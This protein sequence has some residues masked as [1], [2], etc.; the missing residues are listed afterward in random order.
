MSI[1]CWASQ[2]ERILAMPVPCQSHSAR[3][4]IVIALTLQI[5]FSG[6]SWNGSTVAAASSVA[7]VSSPTAPTIQPAL[8]A[9]KPHTGPG[10]SNYPNWRNYTN[11]SDVFAIATNPASNNVWLG[12]TGGVVKLDQ[13]TGNQLAAYTHAD[14]LAT[15]WTTALALD[16]AGKI[17]AGSLG[18]GV[19]RFD[20][21][22]WQVYNTSNSG[23]LANAI[24]TI[25]TDGQGNVWF[26]TG[27]P[28]YSN[29]GTGV[30]KFDGSSW[31]TFSTA[32]S[33]L[34][35]N[36]VKGIAFDSSVNPNVWF[37]TNNGI[38]K[39]SGVNNWQTYNA[40]NLGLASNNTKAV[41]VDGANNI[42]IA[43]DAGVSRFNPGGNSWQNF[44]TSNSALASNN[45][46]SIGVD[47]SGKVWVATDVGVSSYGASN[48]WQD[49]NSTNAGLPAHS[50]VSQLAIDSANNPWFGMGANLTAR[51]DNLGVVKFNGSSWATYDL[52]NPGPSTNEATV[53][54]IDPVNDNKWVAA[55]ITGAVYGY[56]TGQPFGR[57]PICVTLAHQGTAL[58]KFDGTSWITYTNANSGLISPNVSAIA[59][60]SANNKWFGTWAGASKFDGTHWLTY[61]TANSGLVDNSVASVA[62]EGG[63]IEWFGSVGHQDT[64]NCWQGGSVSRFDGSNWQTYT[65]TNSGLVANTINAIAIDKSGNKWFAS[66]N[67]V[68]ITRGLPNPPPCPTPNGGGINEFDGTSWLTYTT[69]NSGLIDNLVKAITIDTNNDKWFATGVGVSRFDG[70]HWYSYTTTN[71]GLLSNY[72]NTIAIDAAGNKWFGTDSGVS[73]FDGT[74][75]YSY[76]M[77]NSGL[78]ANNVVTLAFDRAGNKW[79]GS[80]SIEN[81]NYEV[82]GG[83]S[84]LL[85]IAS[86]VSST[87]TATPNSVRANGS[88]PVLVQVGLRDADGQP[89]ISKTVSLSSSRG[90]SDNIS[91]TSATLDASGIAT[92]TVSSTTPGSATFV[93]TDTTDNLTLPQTASVLFTPLPNPVVGT[94]TPA[95]CD[96]I[97]FKNALAIGGNLSFNCGPNPVTIT[98]TSHTQAVITQTNTTIDGGGLITFSGDKATRVFSVTNGISVTLQNLTVA[99]GGVTNNDNPFNINHPSYGGGL[100]NNGVMTI[101]NSIFLNNNITTSNY[102]DAQRGNVNGGGVYNALGATLNV[103]NSSFSLNTANGMDSF[104]G[105]LGGSGFG[106]GIANDG[107]LII[108]NSTFLNNS[109][110]GGSGIT[111]ISTNVNSGSGL[112]GAIYNNGLMSVTSSTF[113]KN[114]AN[115][116]VSA[117]SYGAGAAGGAIADSGSSADLTISSSL[118][119]SN[120]AG[121]SSSISS[122]FLATGGAI[123]SSNHNINVNNSRFVNNTAIG[124]SDSSGGYSA[125]GGGIAHDKN[126]NL[127]NSSFSNNS[128]VGGN[129]SG[130]GRG[131][132]GQ[133]GAIYDYA[134]VTTV[135]NSTFNANSA[136]GGSGGTGTTGGKGQGG[137]EYVRSGPTGN[138]YN[139]GSTNIINSTF[140]NNQASSGG[141]IVSEGLVTVTNTIFSNDSHSVNCGLVSSGLIS[142]GG[143][144]L[145]YSS[146]GA[147]SCGF[148]NYAQ[149]GDPK[150]GPLQNNGG[151]T[152]TMALPAGS[153]AIDNGNDAVCAV[154]PINNLDQRGVARPIGAHCDIGAFESSAVAAGVATQITATNG[155]NQSTPPNT[156]FGAPLTA[157]VTDV[158]SN[159]VS[160]T[161]VT[162]AAPTASGASSTFANNSPIYTG[163]TNVN[164]VIT[165]TTFQAN[166]SIGSYSVTAS[167]S[168]VITPASFTLTNTVP[169]TPIPT[170]TLTPTPTST[171]TL[172]PTPTPTTTP[173]STPT[174]TPPPGQ[175][176]SYTYNLPL[177]ANEAS[178]ALGNTTTFITF[179]NL[180]SSA[181]ANISVQYYGQADG[182]NLNLNDTLQLPPQGQH[183]ILP[184]FAKGGSGGG[185]VTSDQPLNVVVSE[186]L[187]AGG[188]AYNVTAATASTLYSPLA[189]NGQYGFVTNIVVFNA[190]NTNSTSGKILFFDE[191]GNQIVGATKS[192][193]L[194]AHASQTFNQGAANSGLAANHA[195]WAKIVADNSSA[196]LTGQV[197]E[198]GPANFVATF[199]AITLSQVKSTLY[200]PATFNGQFNFVTGMAIANPNPAP[201]NLTINYYDANGV[202]LLSQPLNIAA[203]GNIGVFQPDVSG[204]SHQV[205]SATLSSDQPLIMAVNERGPATIA[206]TYVAIATGSQSVNLPVIANGF[207]GFVTGAT[208]LN[209]SPTNIAT[210]TLTYLDANGKLIGSLQTKT[211]APHASFLVFQ[212][213]TAQNLP[214]GFFG[215]ALI[216]SDQSLLVTTNALNTANGLFYT[217]TEPGQADN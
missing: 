17:W 28:N 166:T 10:S 145:E 65:P 170:P 94:G 108:A 134:G 62:I 19:S 22:N 137:G 48:V 96:E 112:G 154:S 61:T 73:K 189:L 77:T 38:S 159:P 109:A 113:K 76:T 186:A 25:A 217:Y 110:V 188:S 128:A 169:V 121:S 4:L 75:W 12:T 101:T 83:V 27:S 156:A 123:S 212:G 42:W 16:H 185:V 124:G 202:L 158:N 200:A 84:Q 162:F 144:N 193:S 33:G 210:L 216:I 41:A 57:P 26:G 118:F 157:L 141:A 13:A 115:T 179:Q 164:G 51:I 85:N 58:N 127:S 60:D 11:T 8:S 175:G 103:I 133:G 52:T 142:D 215:T 117:A 206:G 143:Y 30:S 14:G 132:D 2:F 35:S 106:G 178:T 146:G 195:Y 78:L 136:I 125:F 102:N 211:L 197:I 59:V 155:S 209:T 37:A 81:T 66:Y 198:F 79:F 40:A 183:A 153:A 204:L 15:D 120:T 5:L 194:A 116:G 149:S 160:N 80:T 122:P 207:A 104:N 129:G 90:V 191:Q 131:G 180:S 105:N 36:D 147:N 174:P 201:A 138:T 196:T 161:V 99:N 187:N 7:S 165:T 9:I 53:I 34:A 176:N 29:S 1:P 119:D 89:V 71:S 181:P 168:G 88:N 69:A 172:T 92:F 98:F 107:T 97:T 177:L 184:A 199:N 44:N 135:T 72:V 32:N 23:L 63:N 50:G 45:I 86:G 6:F 140:S 55:N 151:P 39:L 18:F 54:I 95:S 213:D 20:G 203:N 21:T 214:N 70:T 167:V 205:S 91:P 43:T 139:S 3:L 152:L 148:T 182:N 67:P 163:T 192:F 150:L 74:N 46:N 31:Q 126:L 82:G 130:S 47:T 87:V 93:A 173:T 208:I 68:R 190:N 171:P 64:N 114:N 24:Q 49:Y 100:Y 56:C 111:N